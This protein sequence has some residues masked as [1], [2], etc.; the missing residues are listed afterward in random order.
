[1]AR[2]A[3]PPSRCGSSFR[4]RWH[5]DAGDR[6]HQSCRRDAHAPASAARY[7]P[8]ALRRTM[9]QDKATTPLRGDAAWR[10]QKEQV[11]KDNA[12]A[13]KRAKEEREVRSQEF[14]K[15]RRAQERRE[16]ASMPKQPQRPK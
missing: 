12:A 2:Q 8:G 10:A 16:A 14:A 4:L 15:E 13:H 6:P 9:K 3:A 7:H 1:M 11:S 5:P